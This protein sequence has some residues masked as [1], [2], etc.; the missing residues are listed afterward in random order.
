MYVIIGNSRARQWPEGVFAVFLSVGAVF[1][2]GKFM[3]LEASCFGGDVHLLLFLKAFTILSHNKSRNLA[4]VK[5]A[6]WIGLAVRLF[7]AWVE[8]SSGWHHARPC[9]YKDRLR[10]SAPGGGYEPCYCYYTPVGSWNIGEWILFCF[11]SSSSC[12]RFFFF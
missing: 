4:V 6:I 5:L 12:T 1:A 7:L 8:S 11:E 10:E 3:N 2:S 9:Y